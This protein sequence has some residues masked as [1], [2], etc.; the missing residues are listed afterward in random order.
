MLK[1]NRIAIIGI[2]VIGLVGLGSSLHGVQPSD[3]GIGPITNVVLG[4]INPKMVSDG[5]ALFASKCILCHDLVQKKIGPP[6]QSVAIN[7]TPEFI[8]NLLLNSAQMQKQDPI[9]KD[10]LR[11]YNIPMSDPGLNQAQARNIL[12]YLRSVAK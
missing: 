1:K 12:E 3:K 5:K 2:V 7:R 8:M 10:L 9:I 4:P 11:K 6:L